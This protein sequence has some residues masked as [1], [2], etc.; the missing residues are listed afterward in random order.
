MSPDL[1]KNEFKV[2]YTTYINANNTQI[3]TV[4]DKIGLK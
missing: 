2:T 4:R 3:Y 1:A